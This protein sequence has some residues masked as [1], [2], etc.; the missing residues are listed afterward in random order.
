MFDSMIR[1]GG[2]FWV[3]MVVAVA[4]CSAND[5]PDWQFDRGDMEAAVFG[6]WT[7]TVTPE[8]GAT[9]PFTREIRSSDETTRSLSCGSRN[10]SEA[11]GTPGL[12]V[13]CGETTWLALS[14][15]LRVEGAAPEELTG[16]FAVHGT[17]FH[18]G[19]LTMHR[20]DTI[21][22]VLNAKYQ[23]GTWSDCASYVPS[24]TC[25]LVERIE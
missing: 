2:T 20:R 3:P 7:G 23:Q 24:R 1:T 25:T 22:V 4:G 8:G 5:E 14:G 12:S 10:F 17:S 6:T 19:Y 16:D 9:L 13:R 21:D 18:E 11:G 15:T